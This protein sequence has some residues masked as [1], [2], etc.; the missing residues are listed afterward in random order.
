MPS[1]FAVYMWYAVNKLVY[2][3]VYVLEIE[4][5]LSFFSGLPFFL[6]IFVFY[7]R[8]VGY[9]ASYKLNFQN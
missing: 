9:I 8:S 4:L 7:L 5:V 6:N 2:M 1:V 3:E